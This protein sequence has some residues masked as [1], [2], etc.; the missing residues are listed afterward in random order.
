[1]WACGGCGSAPPSSEALHC[2]GHSPSQSASRCWRMSREPSTGRDPSCAYGS[3]LSGA[4]RGSAQCC[5]GG[6]GEEVSGER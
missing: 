2:V 3:A 5:E 6:R 1:M 4:E